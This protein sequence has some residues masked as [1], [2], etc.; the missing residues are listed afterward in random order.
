MIVAIEHDTRKRGEPKILHRCTLPLSVTRVAHSVMTP[1][2]VL[3][4]TEP[5]PE[6]HGTAPGVTAAD[7][8]EKHGLRQPGHRTTSRNSTLAPRVPR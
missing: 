5:G 1:L 4:V 7:V 6:L 2:A 8:R 3:D